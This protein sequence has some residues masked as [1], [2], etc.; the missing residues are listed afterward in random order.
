LESQAQIASKLALAADRLRC[1]SR[2][3]ARMGRLST[4]ILDT[5]SG[6][7]AADVAIDLDVLQ[8]DGT[9]R[10]LKQVQTNTDGRTD[11]P[12]LSGGDFKVGTYMLTFHMGAY[13]RAHGVAVADPLFLDLI[14]V[15]F[16]I[17]DADGHY[18]V[19]LLATP[20]SYSTYRGS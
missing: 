16:S 7:P 11:Q 6:K 4:H 8:S 5:V 9:W 13:F 17:A 14:P 19:P 2:K 20:W 18:H 10:R 3:E 15:R 12:L 1:H